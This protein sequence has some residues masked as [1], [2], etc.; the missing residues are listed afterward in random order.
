MS[1]EKSIPIWAKP[2]TDEEWI[3]L[4][5]AHDKASRILDRSPKTHRYA[6][7]LAREIFR[8]FDHGHRDANIMAAI[9]AQFETK[10]VL[11]NIA[12]IK[13]NAVRSNNTQGL[14]GNAT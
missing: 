7:R 6:D 10:L 13:I 3:I 9:A 2:F 11:E 14:V 12:E 5:A 4:Q 8:L 1:L